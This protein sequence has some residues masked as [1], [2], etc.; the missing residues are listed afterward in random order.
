MNRGLMEKLKDPKFKAELD[1][2]NAR[3]S[4]VDPSH[5]YYCRVA[6]KAFA[7]VKDNDPAKAEALVKEKVEKNAKAN[8][9]ATAK[10]AAEADKKA[11]AFAVN[12]LSD[13]WNKYYNADEAAKFAKVLYTDEVA[14]AQAKEAAD[15]AKEEAERVAIVAAEHAAEAK[16]LADVA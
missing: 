15:A 2:A 7:A 12:A 13:Q 8:E 11:T 9:E 5:P 6:A 1:V 4:L 14:D 10:I 3:Q 16:R